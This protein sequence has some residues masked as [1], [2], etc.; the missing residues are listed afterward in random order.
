MKNKLIFTSFALAVMATAWLM[1]SRINKPEKENNLSESTNEE[2]EKNVIQGA[3]DYFFDMRKNPATNKMDEYEMLRTREE[4]YNQYAVGASKT[5][6]ALG[7]KW[8]ELG[9]DNVGGRT[10]AILIDK[11]NPKRI[12]A[13]GVSGGLWISNNSGFTWNKYNDT[14]QSIAI[15]CITQAS[16]GDIYFGTGEGLVGSNAFG[17]SDASHSGM[18]GAG[19]WKSTDD[20]IS[21][22]RLSSTVPGFVSPTNAGWTFINKL[23]TDPLDSNRIYAATNFGLKLSD[24]GGKKWKEVKTGDATDIDVASDGTVLA[25]I[26]GAGYLSAKDSSGNFGTFNQIPTTSGLPRAGRRVEFAIAPSDDNYM[27]ACRATDSSYLQG[28]FQSKNKGQ[29]WTQIGGGRSK[30][31]APLSNAG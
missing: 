18:L 23:A 16:N 8:T 4:V 10:R 2:D 13:G 21:F 27:Y 31:F 14:I 22:K 5:S 24:D 28:V 12:Y 3:I 17:V 7:L 20:G 30:K 19:V 6:A 26:N 25:A 15:S 9:P 11:K 29:T 1:P